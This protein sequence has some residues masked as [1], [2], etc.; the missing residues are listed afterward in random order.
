VD[1]HGTLGPRGSSLWSRH[2]GA[3]TRCVGNNLTTTIEAVGISERQ[4]RRLRRESLVSGLNRAN[5]R[6][7]RA[8]RGRI[9]RAAR[10]LVKDIQRR[11]AATGFRPARRDPRRVIR[12]SQR[13][14]GARRAVPRA[15]T[16]PAPQSARRA[17]LDEDQI[18]AISL[19]GVGWDEFNEMVLRGVPAA[20]S[21]ADKLLPDGHTLFLLTQEHAFRGTDSKD[22]GAATVDSDVE[23]A[24][25]GG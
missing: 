25:R 13:S 1:E 24:G 22:L 23:A 2:I 16:R 8:E 20:L 11:L 12:R 18:A 17:G 21:P 5:E 19:L 14:N 10:V 6:V 7:E 3:L 15:A 4:V 9:R